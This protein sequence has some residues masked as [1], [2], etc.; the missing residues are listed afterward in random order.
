[1]KKHRIYNHI[2]DF[3][4]FGF[5][6]VA[7]AVAWTWPGTVVIASEWWLVGTACIVVAALTIHATMRALRRVATSTN[8]LDKPTELL[9]TGP[10]KLS[11]NP[12]YLANILAVLCCAIA[13]GSWLA[14]LC[15][16]VCFAVL[17][18]L[19]I[20][21]EEHTIHHVFGERYEWYCR[22]VRRWL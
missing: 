18:W 4:L 12:L 6:F 15:P 21:I 22:R 2:P 1:M 3:C 11:R 17:N 8:P 10:F 13:S 16:V 7:F 20:P 5:S 14:L 9:T 19:I